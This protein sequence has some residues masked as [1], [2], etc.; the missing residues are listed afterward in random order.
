MG[1]FSWMTSPMPGK[2]SES[3]PNAHSSRGVRPV[4]LLQ[5]HGQ[6]PI[7]EYAYDGYGVFDTVDAFV[8]LAQNNIRPE[9]TSKMDFDTLRNAGISIDNPPRMYQDKEGNRYAFSGSWYGS[10]SYPG[11]EQILTFRNYMEVSPFDGMDYNAAIEQGVLTRIPLEVV[12]SEV[13]TGTFYPLKFSFNPEAQYDSLPASES[14]P[15]QGYFYDDG[16][17]DDYFPEEHDGEW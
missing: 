3:I 11:H 4:Y 16:D 10:N 15:E 17:E 12:L 14:D 7:V 8:W 2:E 9:L 5:P 1:F 13:G 6:A